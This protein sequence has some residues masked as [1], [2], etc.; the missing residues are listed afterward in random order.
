MQSLWFRKTFTGLAVAGILTGCL[1]TVYSAR[2]GIRPYLGVRLQ[3][4]TPEAGQSGLIL[5]DVNRGGP[6]DQAGLKKGDR[7][8]MAGG[9]AMYTYDDLSSVL[10]DRKPGDELELKVL[11]DGTEQTVRVRLS[12]PPANAVVPVNPPAGAFLGVVSEAMTAEQRRQLGV[13]AEQGVV[14]THVL[15]GSP[16][17]TAGLKRDDVVTHVGAKA[18]A[19]QDQ[20]RDAIR[21]AGVGTEITLKVVRNMQELEIKV[22]PEAM[23]GELDPR[24]LPELP[25]GQG[26]LMGPGLLESLEHLPAL[27]RKVQELEKR[28][29][30]LEQQ[31]LPK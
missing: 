6:A 17:A 31:K 22:R 25:N 8:V 12:Q 5:G 1:Y 14:V 28:V 10:A 24:M 29:R 18:V 19:T 7:I 3:A 30:E 16:A 9:K 23:P 2:A 13:K 20:L 15:P 27:E 21:T 26:R 11:R 4:A